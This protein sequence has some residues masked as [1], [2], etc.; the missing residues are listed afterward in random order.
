M[1]EEEEEEEE[2]LQEEGSVGACRMRSA[3]GNSIQSDAVRLQRR[4][5]G[6]KLERRRCYTTLYLGRRSL[7]STNKSNCWLLL[8]RGK[9]ARLVAPFSIGMYVNKAREAPQF[10]S[11]FSVDDDE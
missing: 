8:S 2:L 11:T 1:E 7:L 6:V 10:C 9:L 4:S 5:E 3:G